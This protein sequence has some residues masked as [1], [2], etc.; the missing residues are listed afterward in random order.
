[1]G[2]INAARHAQKAAK[3]L[4]WTKRLNKTPEHLHVEAVLEKALRDMARVTL[5]VLRQELLTVSAE[6]SMP[7]QLEG[8]HVLRDDM[9]HV[10]DRLLAEAHRKQPSARKKATTARS[11]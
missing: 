5:H 1:M 9:L 3:H 4:G 2:L 8:L 11:K 7:G 6:Q 10:V